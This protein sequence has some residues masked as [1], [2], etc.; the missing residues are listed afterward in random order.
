MAAR[1][2]L[3][4]CRFGRRPSV[5]R[6]P[7]LASAVTAA[8]VVLAGLGTVPAYAAASQVVGASSVGSQAGQSG[9]KS[10]P[11]YDAQNPAWVSRHV[12][13][14]HPKKLSTFSTVTPHFTDKTTG[15]TSR[16]P[17]RQPS[18]TSNAGD[19][20]VPMTA[21]ASTPTPPFT[22]CPAIG[23]DSSCGLLIEITDSGA[24]VY[25]DPSQ[26]PYDGVEDTL[27][28]VVN[29][30]S[31]TMGALALTSS[32]D[33]FGFDG[34]GICGYGGPCDGP[35]GYEGPNT[36]FSDVSPDYA[37]GVVNFPAGLAAGSSTY[38][39]L[40]EALSTSNVS[41][42]SGQSPVTAYEVGQT[43]N[44]RENLKD[45]PTGKPINCATG[46]FWHTFHDLAIPGRGP[47]L[48][49]QRTYSSLL[50]GNDGMF[51]H[52]WS[53][54][55]AMSLTTDS[56][57]VVTVHQENG[58]TIGF[59]PKGYGYTAPSRVMAS[60]VK[61]GDGSFTLTDFHGGITHT[62]SSAGQLVAIGDRNGYTTK[63]S[64]A[65]G[66][67]ASVTDAAGRSL[68][69]TTDAAGHVTDVSDPAGRHLSYTYD[70]AGDL[71]SATDVTGGTWSFGYDSDHQLVTM[72][73]PRGGV[74]S[75]TYD[76]SGRVTKQVDAMG[77]TTTLAYA[78]DPTT[79]SGG[80]TTVT[81]PRGIVTV[82]QYQQLALQ[83]ITH[84]SGTAAAATTTYSF[85]P[86]TLQV[87]SKTDPNGNTTTYSYDRRGNLLTSTDPLGRTTHLAWT[88]LNEP[89][90]I[91][92]P[93]GNSTSFGYD[94]AGNL[95]AVYRSIDAS[96]SQTTS[97]RYGDPAH[98]GDVTSIVDPDGHTWTM[99]YDH[100]GNL[101]SRTDPLGDTTS[102]GYD[103]VGRRT[104][105]VDARGNATGV[106]PSSYTTTY[107][108]NSAGDLTKVTDPLGD[109]TRFGYDANHNRTSATDADGNTT[110]TTYDA[111]DEPTRQTRAD[112]TSLFYA[113]DA[114]G[115]QISQTNAAGHATHY[116]YDERNRVA[117]V[118]DA[119]D[120][121]T[122]YG[123]D[124]AGNLTS[125]ALPSG[126][127]TTLTYDAADERTKQTYSDGK[128]PTVS[129]TY[130]PDGRR[131][132]M[133]DGTGTTSYSYDGLGRVTGQTNGHGQS[134]GYG[135]DP[136]GNLVSL[137]YPTG[138][139][140]T[141]GYDAA[142]RLTSI[143]DW[144]GHTTTL[145]P[146]AA[147]STTSETFGNG[148]T[149][150]FGF[151]ATGTMTSTKDTDPTGATLA[152]LSYTR[153]P[154]RQLTGTAQTGLPG[155]DESYSYTQLNQLAGMNGGTFGYDAAGNITQLLDAVILGYDAADQATTHT[156][157]DG[158][159]TS[160]TYDANGRRTSGPGLAGSSMSYGYDQAGRLTTA[161]GTTSD[162]SSSAG[163]GLIAGGQAHSLAVDS[164]GTV[165][166]WG[167]NTH[168][169]LGD[170]TTT[171]T[172][173]PVKTGAPA[174]SAVT[175][176]LLS[177]AALTR[178]GTVST[179]GDNAYGQLGDGTTTQRPSPVTVPGLSNLT[180]VA[181][182]N[183]HMLALKSDGTVVAWGLDN[184]GQLGDGTTDTGNS[185]VTVTGSNADPTSSTPVDVKGL[186]DVVQVA[187]GGLPGYAGHSV[188]LKADGTVWAWGYGKSGQLGLGSDTS[189][190]TPTKVP[191][192]PRI[193][194]V[195]ASGDN[196]YALGKDGSVWAWGDNG[197]GQ[198]GNP[199]ARHT[200]SSPIQVQLPGTATFI[201]AGGTHALA[202][203]GDGTAWGWGN[204]NTG[205]LGDSGAC[206]KTCA[207]PVKITGLTDATILAA[208][209]VHSL[210]ALSDGT[211]RGWGRN[212]ESELGDGTTTVRLTPAAVT[213]LNGIR[214]AK[215]GYV[216]DGDGLRASH[217]AGGS[218]QHFAWSLAS[219][220]P[221]LLTDDAV[222]Y[223]YDD[224]GLP[225]EQ[226]DSSGA[227]LYF[228]HDQYGSTRMLTDSAGAAVATYTYDP[229][230]NLTSKTGT[231]DTALRW[232]GQYQDTDTGLYYLRAR[233]YDPLTAQ[234][235]T[236]D[237]LVALTQQTYAYAGDNPLT[238]VDPLGLDWWNPTTW[239]SDTWAA[240]GVGLGA[241][242][243]AATGVGLVVDLS[244]GATLV[245]GTIAVGSGLGATALDYQPCMN[246]E[247]FACGGLIM[248]GVG[249][250][251]G[252][253]GYV[254]DN[255]WEFEG[256]D[257]LGKGFDIQAMLIG[258]TGTALDTYS[259]V[260]KE[261]EAQDC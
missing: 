92:D 124:A 159:K 138:K 166:A 40:E 134:V 13:T 53:S 63:L 30:S 179:W 125:L 56:A 28:G 51:G 186:T 108:Y 190:P 198:M 168:G 49:L 94:G 70:S 188:A 21:A 32:T 224:A 185:T 249:S 38:F 243:L 213:G 93:A 193:M 116:A 155:G 128:T 209:Y 130:D 141:R 161:T 217:T 37:S 174:S 11:R 60:L 254:L 97:Y 202:L 160:L 79:T 107:A 226:I 165:W 86:F 144:N 83:S 106:D 77:R 225:V 6:L 231:A 158:T 150:R 85:D 241:V 66:S 143:T 2:H 195:A 59:T 1:P 151:D 146:D 118:T 199:A 31:K 200:Q 57:G 167:D 8:A 175:A 90:S 208:G 4:L 137:T 220:V 189:T 260:I 178:D 117:T 142:E 52:G 12:R 255:F 176:G 102:Y 35:T 9:E 219:K 129:Y 81:D 58:S 256:S 177:S 139:S 257:L 187:A 250:L 204:N 47:S 261:L 109:V 135:Y 10:R 145:T 152:S 110:T 34:D 41:T 103:K 163:A 181:A 133:A 182:G 54:S 153:D 76:A 238:F 246:G 75:N 26:G 228:Q 206:G 240:I 169:Q 36:S 27:I 72:T 162:A 184:A 42:G 170:G 50:A 123:Y 62:F 235:L 100:D 67:L 22:E 15:P 197:Y 148:V 20:L 245:A 222:A 172:S 211:M 194:Q 17:S 234:F 120:R 207:T 29:D 18:G 64:Y 112:G 25:G 3:S 101:T 80:T 33:L 149:A 232:N 192:L 114:D 113:Y 157:A 239:S 236:V 68:T 164:A 121:A 156:T 55:Y 127:T 105:M 237:P 210:A 147:G 69:F 218:T 74:V 91:T 223:L 84:A 154:N 19:A 259:L 216:Y 78:G 119:L 131:A 45:C 111:D 89:S 95:T 140:V 221:L 88:W 87:A 136:V 24:V 227:S 171:G 191:G 43:P 252:G 115:N 230:G 173:S 229:Y 39:S 212:N 248:G 203:T 258:G 180:Q 61:N 73:D 7:R 196:T 122:G 205:Q 96:T 23:A 82:Q 104:S 215:A 14:D 251:Y 65:G 5:H 44:P 132:T 233:Y 183:Y 242:A 201:A 16:M 98:P 126:A 71:T 99:G 244:A 253:G 48:D 214:A 46:V 247:S